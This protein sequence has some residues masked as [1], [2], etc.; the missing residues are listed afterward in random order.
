MH[1]VEP[2]TPAWFAARNGAWSASRMPALM[3]DGRKKGE[4]GD[5]AH[6]LVRT[7]AMERLTGIPHGNFVTQA[8]TDGLAKEPAALALYAFERDLVLEPAALVMHPTIPRACATPDSFVP[9]DGLL[10]V[11]APA[12]R[13]KHFDALTGGE[14]RAAVEYEWQGRM[15]MFCTGRAWVDI[16]SYCPDFDDLQL[17]VERIHRDEAKEAQMAERIA[18]AEDEVAKL[19]ARIERRAA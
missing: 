8:M 12:D 10:E 1:R 4:P 15:Q 2:N 7:V 9:V 16:V 6:K 11:K 3:S 17:A 18:W 14:A 19:F 5:K 13:S